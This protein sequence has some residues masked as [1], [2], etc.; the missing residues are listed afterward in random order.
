MQNELTH[1]TNKRKH[2]Q[3]A[4]SRE[5]S[6]IDAFL[7]LEEAR[8]KMKIPNGSTP[9]TLKMAVSSGCGIGSGIRS[10]T[11]CL[12]TTRAFYG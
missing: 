2:V 6:I 12:N 8:R 5:L 7:H 1:T 11:A 9:L 10:I 3:T 4:T